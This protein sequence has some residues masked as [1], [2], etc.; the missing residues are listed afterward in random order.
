M[1]LAGGHYRIWVE[2]PPGGDWIDKSI[3]TDTHGFQNGSWVHAVAPLTKRSWSHNWFKP[4]ARIGARGNDE[5][6]LD[7]VDP[8]APKRLLTAEITARRSG[9]LFLY[10][11]DTVVGPRQLRKSFYGNNIG[12]ATVT[13]ERIEAKAP[14][15]R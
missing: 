9:E 10:V 7:A 6:P 15:R 5:Y 12:T 8:L 13:V 4:I 3:P 1:L 14:P 11:N 2:V